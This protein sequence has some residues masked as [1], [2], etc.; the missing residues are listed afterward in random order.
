MAAVE[1]RSNKKRQIQFQQFLFNLLNTFGLKRHAA[2]TQGRGHILDLV[3]TPGL[4]T[5]VSSGVDRVVSGAGGGEG[6]KRSIPKTE[7]PR[8]AGAEGTKRKS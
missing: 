2:P 1:M 5:H 8:T 3:R 4:S 6:T 7:K